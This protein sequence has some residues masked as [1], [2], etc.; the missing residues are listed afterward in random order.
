MK[1]NNRLNECVTTTDGRQIWV[2]RSVA[3]AV[4]VIV[5]CDE[6]P[7]VLV[8]Q[9]GVGVPDFQGYWNLVCGYLDYDETT[10]EAAVREVWEECGVNALELLK[11]SEVEYFSKPWDVGST[12]NGEKQ[13]VTIH[14]GLYA[15]VDQLPELSNAN[16]E[17]DETADIRWLPLS[18]VDTIEYA[19][20]HRSRIDKFLSHL[21]SAAKI[22]LM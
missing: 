17:P 4:T 10:E 5:V 22:N 8:N 21:Q 3:V 12:P 6:V 13:N 11:H 19:F 2:S 7:Y 18:E 20:N 16:N 9:R 14:H 15:V 1:F